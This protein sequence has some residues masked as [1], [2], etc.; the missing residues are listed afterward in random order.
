MHVWPTERLGMA[1]MCA[2]WGAA[3]FVFAE[4]ARATDTKLPN[5]LFIVADDLATRLGCYGDAAAVTPRLDA[6]AA[7]HGLHACLR[8]GLGLHAQ[9]H[10]VHARTQ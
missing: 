4:E 5:I 6:L 9:P 3:V 7:G 2:V 1:A 8:A 10:V